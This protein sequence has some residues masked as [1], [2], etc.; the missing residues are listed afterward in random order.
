MKLKLKHLIVAVALDSGARVALAASSQHPFD[1]PRAILQPILTPELTKTVQ[2]IVDAHQIPGLALAVVHKEGPPELG[3]WGNR[4]EDGTRMTTDTLFNI[5]SCSKAFLA[6]SLGPQHHSAPDWLSTLSWQTKLADILPGD[7]KLP[8]PWASQKA[9]LIDILSHVSASE[10]HRPLSHDLS[11]KGD[12]SVLDV[13]RKL[14]NLRPSRELREKFIYITRR[15]FTFLSALPCTPKV[16]GQMYI[17]GAQV[18][19][20]LSGVPYA[21]FVK[22]RIFKP[23]NM[24]ESTF[25]VDEAVRT[26]R[27]SETWTFFGRRIPLW[28][29]ELNPDLMAGPGG[30]YPVSKSWYYREWKSARPPEGSIMGYGLG[31]GRYSYV[32]HDLITHNGGAP[33]VSTMTTAL[34]SDGIGVIALVNADRKQQT[35]ANITLAI[36]R[37]LINLNDPPS[38]IVPTTPLAGPY[39][40][41]HVQSDKSLVSGERHGRED[42]RMMTTRP[43]SPIV[44]LT[45]TYYDAGY[46]TL[47]LCNISSQ[48]DACRPVLDDFRLADKPSANDP[49]GCLLCGLLS[50]PGTSVFFP[51]TSLGGI[52]SISNGKVKGVGFSEIGIDDTKRYE[53]IEENSDVWFTKQVIA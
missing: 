28:I 49:D 42:D 39:R 4:S 46:G 48:S 13:I 9:N 47:T 52:M 15:A 51:P 53:S 36:A 25:N 12:D 2:E 1:I 27:A 19:T 16:G 17:V 24:T 11:Y 21:D 6:A 34:I 41:P 22:N 18:I 32:G 43:L 8:D 5:A 26:G 38:P 3:A 23:L 29:E 37:K 40:R 10:G 33:G 50:S 35:L 44:D 20:A 45:G 7:W 31:W 14:R 30:L